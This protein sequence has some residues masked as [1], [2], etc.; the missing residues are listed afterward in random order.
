MCPSSRLTAFT[1]MASISCTMILLQLP[2]FFSSELCFCSWFWWGHVSSFHVMMITF[3]ALTSPFLLNWC[4]CSWPN[5]LLPAA[6]MFT[7]MTSVSSSN[8][9]YVQSVKYGCKCQICLLYQL[10]RQA[11]EISQVLS[12]DKKAVGD[13][14]TR[15][16]DRSQTPLLF[17]FVWTL[18]CFQH[19]HSGHDLNALPKVSLRLNKHCHSINTP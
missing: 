8:T 16:L 14:F 2:P 12:F 10:L 19:L 5:F 3:I 4:L 13:L 1:L 6:L 18:I 7:F 17:L 9:S 15:L 11:S